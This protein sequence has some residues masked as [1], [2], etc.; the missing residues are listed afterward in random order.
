MARGHER[1]VG[2]SFPNLLAKISRWLQ[3][4][5]P[6]RDVAKTRLQLILIQDRSGV[7]PAI[8]EALRDDL[9]EL[10]GRYFDVSKEGIEVELQR[11]DEKAAL[12][13]NVPIISLKGR[14]VDAI[15]KEPSPAQS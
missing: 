7:D 10:M 6:S 1:D 8:L 5:P 4:Q 14:N 3:G 9:I 2:M 12:I 15:K 13:V 11:D